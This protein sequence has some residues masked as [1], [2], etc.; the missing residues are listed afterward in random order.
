MHFFV[1]VSQLSAMN[2]QNLYQILSDAEKLERLRKIEKGLVSYIFA[3]GGQGELVTS[4]S[5][6]AHFNTGKL[7]DWTTISH[8]RDDSY[9]RATGA[10]TWERF[11]AACK[12]LHVCEIT[13]N[14]EI[15]NTPQF[16][17]LLPQNI[18]VTNQCP[19]CGRWAPDFLNRRKA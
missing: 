17:H 7:D 2:D 11:L 9:W 4:V 15:W 6:K 16:A 14:I 12:K 5:L 13:R 18:I 3:V 1:Y 19:I 10:I 8:P